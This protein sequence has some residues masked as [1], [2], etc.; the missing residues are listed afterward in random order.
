MMVWKKLP[1]AKFTF[2][3][4]NLLEMEKWKNKSSFELQSL[5]RH[6]EITKMMLTSK[7]QALGYD[8][9]K[10]EGY[11]PELIVNAHSWGIIKHFLLKIMQESDYQRLASELHSSNKKLNKNRMK[12][13]WK[14]AHGEKID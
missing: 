10:I 7:S 12:L 1:A 8:L 9:S 14:A 5:H 4:R 3:I 6:M 2:E 11:D 13:L